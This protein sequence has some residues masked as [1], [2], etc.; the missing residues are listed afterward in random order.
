MAE[1]Q[2]R[3]DISTSFLEPRRREKE[4]QPFFAICPRRTGTTHE[5]LIIFFYHDARCFNTVAQSS[6]A[7]PSQRLSRPSLGM[8]RTK[9]QYFFPKD[10]K[11]NWTNRDICPMHGHTQAK[12]VTAQQIEPLL[13]PRVLERDSSSPTISHFLAFGAVGPCFRPRWSHPP[14]VLFLCLQRGG[15]V[16]CLAHLGH[17]RHDESWAASS[18]SSVL[19]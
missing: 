11:F 5:F 18:S 1:L 4:I 3:S 8:I 9:R 19:R 16:A 7:N 10:P 2:K 6:N 17:P 13:G 14:S 12:R 15:H